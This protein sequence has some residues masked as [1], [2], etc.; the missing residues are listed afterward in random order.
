MSMCTVFSCVGRKCFL[1]PVSS[2]GKTLLGFAL[3]N[4]VLQARPNLPVTPGISWLH[5]F[6]FQY[7]MM[8]NTSFFFFFF[9]IVLKGLLVLHRT[10]QPKFLQHYWSGH[11]LGVLWY[12]M[13][14][15]GN[16]QRSFCHFWNCT[17]ILLSRMIF[18]FLTVRASPFLLRYSCPQ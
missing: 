12:W 8:E 15:L 17:Q 5:T 13:V 11:R 6:A 10:S 7:S 14:C 9:V 3:F 2:L 4:F 18:F 16:E 1:W